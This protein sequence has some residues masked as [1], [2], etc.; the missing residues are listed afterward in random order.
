MGPL[1]GVVFLLMVTGTLIVACYA[2][3]KKYN[4]NRVQKHK[5]DHEY[6]YVRERDSQFEEGASDPIDMNITKAYSESSRPVNTKNSEAYS[7]LEHNEAYCAVER[8]SGTYNMKINEAYSSSGPVDMKLNA[9]YG[10]PERASDPM[11]LKI[12]QAYVSSGQ[13]SIQNLIDKV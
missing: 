4:N 2:F 9:A 1:V 8:E 12:N 6:S 13:D 7:A 11:E 5:I 10:A 3:Y